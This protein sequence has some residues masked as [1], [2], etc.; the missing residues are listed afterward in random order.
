M[1]LDRALAFS[2]YAER[3]L[4]NAPSL[5]ADL[6]ARLDA[7]FDWA[8]AAVQT[9]ARAVDGNPA[10]LAVALRSLRRQVFLHTLLRDL[11]GRATL[12]EVVQTMSTLAERA[13]DVSI[14]VH[15][16]ALADVHGLPMGHESGLPQHLITIGLGKLGGRELNVSSDID[17]V[18]AYPE[19]GETGG[20]RTISN[21]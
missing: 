8:D 3:A 13:L 16:R 4:T 1:D 2:R 15:T 12:Q 10:A 20:P 14:R 7:P 6:V 17:L 5:R 18:F 9:E 11:T 19:E 21:R